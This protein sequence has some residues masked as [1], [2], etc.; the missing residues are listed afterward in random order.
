MLLSILRSLFFLK[1]ALTWFPRIRTV[2]IGFEVAM[3][4]ANKKRI[5]K[6]T[7]VLSLMFLTI[8]GYQN[9]QNSSFEAIKNDGA[10]L[11]SLGETNIPLSSLY[12][13]EPVAETATQGSL[14]LKGTCTSNLNVSIKGDIATQIETSCV[15]SQ[16]QAAIQLAG[17]DGDK[18]I[19]IVQTDSMGALVSDSRMFVKDTVPPVMDIVSVGNNAVIGQSLVISGPCESNLEVVATV[20]TLSKTGICVAGAYEMTMDLSSLLDGN[21]SLMVAQTDRARLRGEKIRPIKKDT[22][23]P[24]VTIASPLQG[25]SV[26][27]PVVVTGQCE[28][29]LEVV[30]SIKDL[31]GSQSLVC[32]SSMSYSISVNLF[33]GSGS[34]EIQVTQTDAARN[35]TTV[36]RSVVY[37]APTTTLSILI[38]SPAANSKS[39]NSVNLQGT[40]VQNL[41]VRI[42]GTGV[43]AE[44]NIPCATGTFQQTV[45][46]SAGDGSK[47]VRVSQTNAFGD[48]GSDVR[49]FIRDTTPPTLTLVSPSAGASA[50]SG[51]TLVGTCETGQSI[52]ISGSGV[53]AAS[54]LNCVSSSFNGA[55]LF[56]AN[57]GNKT[58]QLTQADSV[59]NQSTVSRTF[60]K[61]STAPLVQITSPFSGATIT[62][63]VF[64][65]T[66]SCETNL[67]VKIA[68][69]GVASQITVNCLN[70]MFSSEVNLISGNGNKIVQVSQTDLAGNIG[71]S[72]RTFVLEL[73]P[74]PVVEGITWSSP[75][76]LSTNPAAASVVVA[77]VLPT[78]NAGNSEVV[79]LRLQNPYNTALEAQL[80][81]FGQ[82]FKQGQ[83]K[84][85][86]DLYAVSGSAQ[87]IVQM[88]IKN[89]Y[90]DGS[91]RFAVLTMPQPA[92]AANTYA[93]VMFKTKVSQTLLPLALTHFTNLNPT[94]SFSFYESSGAKTVVN[95]DV[96]AAIA[97]ELAK[98]TKDM[99]LSGP[100]AQQ[101][102]IALP[103]RTSLRVVL[104]I[105]A[106][107]NSSYVFDLQ[108]NN[109]IAMASQGGNHRYDFS[110][111]ASGK[112][113]TQTNLTHYQYSQWRKQVTTQ[114]ASTANLQHDVRYLVQTGFVLPYNIDVGAN[115]SQ[116]ESLF[117]AT[118]SSDWGK[119][120]APHGIE[121]NMPMTGGRG[122]IGAVTQYIA[123]W[124]VSQDYRIRDYVMGQAE[125]S[126]GIPWHFWDQVN[127][128]WL[129]VD[130]YPQVWLDPRGGNPPTGLTQQV[131]SQNGWNPESAHNPSLSYIPYLMTGTRFHL[132]Q[133]N[134]VA[135]W[136]IMGAWPGAR[137]DA[138]ALIVRWT[139]VRNGAWGLRDVFHASVA[140][141][142]GTSH[143]T[144]FKKILDSNLSWMNSNSATWSSEQGEPYGYLPGEYGVA[145]NMAPW[146]QDYLASSIVAIARSGNAKAKTY[147]NWS[148][149]FLVE[150]FLSSSKGFN[151]RDGIAYNITYQNTKTWAAMGTATVNSGATNGTGWAA[152]NGNYGQ[153]GLMTLSLIYEVTKNPRA[154]EAFNW[155]KSANPPYTTEADFRGDA[156]QNIKPPN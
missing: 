37:S 45:N 15:N 91:V 47:E 67:P 29:G 94:M 149:N 13:S 143:Q 107:A 25:A 24:V 155:L 128:S 147:L 23:P 99:W 35:S 5:V 144:Y 93:N 31:P 14:T 121:K 140:N 100:L 70:A 28:A 146:Q 38:S 55:I 34:K 97:A 19:Q 112:T 48:T 56:S 49:T 79:S 44:M 66:G 122:D 54:S 153:L 61:D 46:F 123:M 1:W 82:T 113:I 151:P 132:D 30:A 104:D 87:A 90:D 64:S 106:Y 75:L 103:V 60:I 7:I 27:S 98:A 124:L 76:T 111:S 152:S 74:P 141:P 115:K 72:S 21:L 92:M 77:P 88:D 120:F 50:I 20:G 4:T 68:G 53:S 62:S 105:T 150:R 36:N 133:Q 110:F 33:S 130:R 139:Q 81:T 135:S 12:I 114:A 129:S 101:V 6:K 11:S 156:S 117:S 40:C 39:Q 71:Q 83:V 32:P 80:I 116:I 52:N 136:T 125:A 57:D 142:D 58:I 138:Q 96:K 134:A 42:F 43:A 22:V 118:A 127:Q 131:P 69:S 63:D 108:V 65:L 89:R 78:A 86:Q 51:V 16:F 26:T 119:P 102:R 17:A 154:L 148:S 109:D 10:S 85:G 9:C 2:Y 95:L 126:A 73:A 137:L 145:G 59:G 84:T 41:Q 3:K 8:F 18:N